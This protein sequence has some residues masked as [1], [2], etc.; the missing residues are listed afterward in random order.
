MNVEIVSVGSEIVSGRIADTNAAYLASR[1]GDLGFRVNRH[2]AAD[3]RYAEL[4]ALLREVAAR[5]DLAVVTGGLGPTRDDLTREVVA[6]LVGAQ[7]VEDALARENIVAIFAA[8]GGTPSESNY[9][10]ALAPRGSRVIQNPT[11]TACGMDLRIGRCRIFCLPGVPSEMKVMFERDVVPAVRSL[12][13]QVRRVR[14][15]HTFGMAES[16]IG[17]RLHDMMAEEAN[18][19]LATQASEGVITLR[20]T[21]NAPAPDIADRLIETAEREVRR[22]IGNVIFGTDGCTLPMAVARLLEMRSM[23]LAIAESCTGGEIAARL[24]DVPGISRFLIEGIVAYAND[25]KIRRLGVPAELI[26][27]EGAVSRPVAEAMALG[28]RQ[29]SGADVALSVTG[30]AGPGGG[31]PQKPV[32]LVFFA[33]ADAQG[34]RSEEANIRGEREIIRNRATKRALNMLRL[35]LEESKD[36]NG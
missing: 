16:V 8:R 27:R 4:A 23:K 15:L 31:T 3:D 5:A 21:A 12:S 26:E 18:P 36:G 2:S 25:A 30:I 9:K 1:L 29:T 14:S 35:Y 32:G 22:R 7:L 33:L 28:M 34:V 10:Q 19:E 13:G 24:T 11:G 17:E 20:L 6:E